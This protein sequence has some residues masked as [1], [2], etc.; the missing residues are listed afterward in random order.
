[1]CVFFVSNAPLQLSVVY[2]PDDKS[3]NENDVKNGILK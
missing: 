3:N 1:M 2:H